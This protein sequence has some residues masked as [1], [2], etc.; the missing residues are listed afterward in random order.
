MKLSKDMNFLQM[1]TY[2]R[3]QMAAN[4]SRTTIE[5]ELKKAFEWTNTQLFSFTDVFYTEKK[6]V[7]AES[8]TRR[9]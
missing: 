9:K 2:V 6:Y 4:K 1:E 7:P 5:N 3:A 8:F